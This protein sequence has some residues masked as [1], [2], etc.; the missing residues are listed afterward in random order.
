MRG[1]CVN[2]VICLMGEGHV[3]NEARSGRQ[4]VITE[5]LML[6]FVKTGAS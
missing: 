4:S 1:M 2:G 6:T 5:N 3:H